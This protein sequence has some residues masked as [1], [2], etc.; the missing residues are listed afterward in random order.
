MGIQCCTRA[1]F[2]PIV[3]KS[4]RAYLNVTALTVGPMPRSMFVQLCIQ[5]DPPIS[6]FLAGYEFASKVSLDFVGCAIFLELG[7]AQGAE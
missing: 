2:V 1:R 3:R 4:T 7:P 5:V 6:T